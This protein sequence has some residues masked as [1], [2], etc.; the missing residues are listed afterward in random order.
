[1]MTTELGLTGRVV[2]RGGPFPGIMPSIG[3]SLFV[4]SIVALVIEN[5][6]EEKEML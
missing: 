3:L 6:G 4:V 5:S 1:M 2:G